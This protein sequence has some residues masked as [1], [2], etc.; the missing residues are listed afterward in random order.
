MGSETPSAPE[1]NEGKPTA[2]PSWETAP[3]SEAYLKFEKDYE[4]EKDNSGKS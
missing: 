1:Q 2:Q 3:K 4:K